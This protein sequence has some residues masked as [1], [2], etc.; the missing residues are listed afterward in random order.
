MMMSKPNGK[1]SVAIIGIGLRGEYMSGLVRE[2]TDVEIVALVDS[3]PE[4]AVWLAKRLKLPLAKVYRSVGELLQGAEFDAAM[5]FTPDGRHAEVAIPLLKA[6]KRIFCEKPLEITEDKCRALIQADEEAGGRTFVGFNLRYAPFYATVKRCLEEG[7]VGRIL[8]VQADEFYDGGRTYFRRW[9]GLRAESGGLWITKAS[10]DF[11]LLL[12][13]TGA[14][15][16]TVYAHASRT[17][18]VPRPEA[19]TQCRDCALSAQC[20]D[21]AP[22][23]PGELLRI[24]ED[25]GGRPHDLCLFNNPSDT[26]DHGIAQIRFDGDIFATYTCN[27]VAGFTDR[28]LR[29]SG[30]NGTVEGHLEGA[31]VTVIRRDPARIESIPVV[32]AAGSHGGADPVMVGRFLEFVRDGRAPACTP[33]EASLPVL[34]GLAATRS[35]DEGR[36]IFMAL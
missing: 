18:Y 14:R 19:G 13:L 29:I 25:Q 36:P 21:K 31:S 2:R 30:T 9:N 5:L 20:A 33:R 32:S 10:H 27:V 16:S 15:P 34:M 11:D 8:T 3:I 1:I 22:A 4:K 17:Y 35:G 24:T 12:W 26:F 6:G 7:L 23:V 28:R